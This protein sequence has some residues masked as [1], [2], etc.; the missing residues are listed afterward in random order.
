M[1]NDS[2]SPAQ[3]ARNR[4]LFGGMIGWLL[5]QDRR[6]G[7]T[8]AAV[9]FQGRMDDG[10]ASLTRVEGA[11]QL[12]SPA[13]GE[14]VST[15]EVIRLVGA[16][17]FF[18][19]TVD[20]VPD[21][22]ELLFKEAV[23]QAEVSI[24]KIDAARPHI[25][26]LGDSDLAANPIPWVMATAELDRSVRA[27]IA[28]IM[29]SIAAGEAQVNRWVDTSGGWSQQEDRLAVAEKCKV[30]AARRGQVISL[31]SSPYQGLQQAVKRRNTFIHPMPVPEAVPAT[32]AR[33]LVPG[34]S[35]SV[36]A[37]AAC[38]AVRSSFI[39]LARLL[40][41]PIPA[42]LAYCPPGPPDD[43]ESWL[44]ASVLTGIRSDPDF[45]PN[46]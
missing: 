5:S 9:A 40:E 4:R 6:P 20:I 14:Q 17:E 33:A 10:S 11:W 1:S 12:V 13:R 43:D 23:H 16:G 21:L 36:E 22:A 42:Y 31:G 39:D 37:R 46:S 2:V 30:L 35:L 34:H 32:G 24:A 44:S 45:P 15:A 3:Q 28:S 29:L 41:V 38:L 27:S 19:R 25:E 26:A 8:G 18:P 7:M